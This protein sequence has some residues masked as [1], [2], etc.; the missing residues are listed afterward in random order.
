MNHLCKPI[1]WSCCDPAVAKFIEANKSLQ[2]IS[3]RYDFYF[4]CSGGSINRVRELYRGHHISCINDFCV[5]GNTLFTLLKRR[6]NY[7]VVIR[8]DMDAIVFDVE[9][10][11][12]RAQRAAGEQLLVGNDSP[13]KRYAY[14]RGG[15]NITSRSVI[16][17]IGLLHSDNPS[18]F[19]PVY[20][21]SVEAAGGKL[22]S[23]PIFEESLAYSGELPVWHPLKYGGNPPTIQQFRENIGR[24]KKP[25]TD[26]IVAPVTLAPSKSKPGARIPKHMHFF[27]GDGPLSWMRYLTLQS[28][29]ATN[30]DWQATLHRSSAAITD[31]TWEEH[32][33]QDFFAY[34]GRDYTNQL[35]EL[36]LTLDNDWQPPEGFENTPKD[37]CASHQSNFFKWTTLA[38]QGGWYSDL[39]ILYVKSL[40]P[41]AEVMENRSINTGICFDGVNLLIGFMCS[42]PDN[43]FF[44]DV[45]QMAYTCYTP[46]K[47]QCAGIHAIYRMLYGKDYRRILTTRP[48][49][50]E[51]ENKYPDLTVYRIPTQ[52]IYPWF[53]NS[54]DCVFEQTHELPDETVGIHWYGGDPLSQKYN[55]AMNAGNYGG[56][57]NTFTATVAKVLPTLAPALQPRQSVAPDTDLL[58]L[59]HQPILSQ[60]LAQSEIPRHM[61]LFWGSSPLS[62]LRYL[63]LK[64]FCKTNPNWQ[65]T[66]HL[67]QA[68]IT[69]KPWKNDNFQDFFA[70]TGPD[71]MDQARKLPIT[72]DENWE[73]PAYY[74][75]LPDT[76]GPSHKSNFFKWM[77]LAEEGGWYADFD[78]LFLRSLDALHD[79]MVAG[80][81]NTGVCSDGTNLLIGFMFS[82]PNNPFFRDV[83]K[84][85]YSCYNPEKYQCVGCRS[86]YWMLY[87][88]EF[89]KALTYR[90]AWEDLK[91]TYPE[92]SFYNIPMHTV[93]PWPYSRM[94]CVFERRYNLGQLHKDTVGLHWF[95]GSD[96]AQKYNNLLSED[97]CSEH[98][99]T[100]TILTEGV[101]GE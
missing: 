27:W 39:D 98:D 75:R 96:I 25:T 46:T 4:L 99:N 76:M 57:K 34:S 84:F 2:D 88:P 70:Y 14:V 89:S 94:R 26:T 60:S 97:T 33:T 52:Q 86:I 49:L 61:H 95:G 53:Y 43:A 35:A 58:K 80:S 15:C 1:F 78:I 22:F 7:D 64:S 93:Y 100:F 18:E 17:K 11:I 62:W 28:F 79:S 40:N 3:A 63:T 91:E 41:L 24:Y 101:F 37:I 73:P 30:P 13:D 74:D 8:L 9:D 68:A 83:A 20:S 44:K 77:T 67:A 51:V 10:L 12:N 56:Y 87:G 32:N 82:T 38:T 85:A 23:S 19:D 55:S 69:G 45:A 92:L 16:D 81:H 31:K 65:V 29:C 21:A 50:T 71:Y 72:I 42:T 90:S 5:K 59:V 36:P 48:A 47:Y 6:N 66:L 54:L